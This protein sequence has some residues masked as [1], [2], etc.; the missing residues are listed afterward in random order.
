LWR[1]VNSRR[2]P[3]LAHCLSGEHY[4]GPI[5]AGLVIDHLCENKLCVNPDH[6]EAVSLGEKTRRAAAKRAESRAPT[7][8]ARGKRGPGARHGQDEAPYEVVYGVFT[9]PCRMWVRA[10]TRKMGIQ[11]CSSRDC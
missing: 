3:V 10:V 6:L 4:R 8:R 9:T 5:P 1:Q 11:R 2:D 7:E